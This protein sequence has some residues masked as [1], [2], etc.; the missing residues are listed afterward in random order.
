MTD[1]VHDSVPGQCGCQDARDYEDG[2]GDMP[3][4]VHSIIE[5]ALG[6][7]SAKVLLTATGLGLFDALEERALGEA[8]IQE[9]FGI[10]K[11]GCHDFLSVL[12]KLGL[13]HRDGDQY[14]NS[15]AA[16]EYLVA[17]KPA[18]VGG[19]LERANHILYPAWSNF[20]DSLATGA[21][22]PEGV[23]LANMYKHVYRNPDRMRDIIETMDAING[24]LGPKLAAAF[25][26]SSV[27]SF[28][29]I[30][31]A[32]GN[33][34]A[35]LAEAHPHLAGTVF[36]LPPVESM[37]RKYVGDSAAGGRVTFQGGDFFGSELPRAD[38]LIFGHVL[39]DWPP[40]RKQELI[41]KAY[42]A[43]NPG[44][45]LLIFDP[46]LD[47]DLSGLENFLTSLSTLVAAHGGSEYRMA[48][49]KQWIRLAGFTEIR[50]RLL[51]S[52]DILICSRKP[53][54]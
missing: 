38:V 21:S 46:M 22:Q 24:P 40:E 30:G 32:R 17:G 14:R 25:D 1:L 34:A 5:L 19:F 37:F 53:R 48:D 8:G 2:P 13:L 45:Y 51:G 9:R 35:A 7:C 41:A 10:H 26:W 50:G 6:F 36:D 44:G 52:S 23:A 49:C 3:G 4:D 12:V 43:I 11:R 39:E 15:A 28:A 31:G 29:D 18:Y 54:L 42:R 16:S 27:A 33:L 47:D 20:G